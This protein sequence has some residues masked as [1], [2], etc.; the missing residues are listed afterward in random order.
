MTH[1]KIVVLSISDIHLGHHR[2]SSDVICQRLVHY[3]FP[4]LETADIIFIGG[5]VFDTLLYYSNDGSNTI[6]AFLIDFL[7][8]C[9]KHDVTV[10]ILRGTVSHDRDQS[11]MFEVLHK[12]YGFKNS[13]AYFDTVTCEYIESLDIKVLYV[14]DNLPYKTSDECMDVVHHL[15][16]VNNWNKFD[17]AIVHGNFEHMLKLG[18]SLNKPP[19]TFTIEQFKNIIARFVLTGHIHTPNIK[20]FVIQN[21]S[22][23]R[24]CHG[25]EEAKGFISI[26]D[27][28][29]SSKIEFV[30]NDDATLFITLDLSDIEDKDEVIK[31][32]IE[33]T[34]SNF[35]EQYGH[36]R[37]IHPSHEVKQIL[38]KI[39]HEKFPRL[40][41][42]HKIVKTDDHQILH[43]QQLLDICD[44]PVPTEDNLPQMVKDFIK[45]DMSMDRIKDILS[46]S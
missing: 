17:Y 31:D 11:S 27:Y 43:V 42:T 28:R 36:V 13:L 10:R 16:K 12:R 46:Q 6:T 15:L 38:S 18:M 29:D 19:C 30:K 45:S 37:V 40:R 24:L 7:M 22:F 41:Y 14:P 21:G 2:V 44:Y 1:D 4:R 33:R 25:E 20:D 34:S 32:F 5:D 35:K 39:C 8:H 26:T 3:L 23:D 9:D